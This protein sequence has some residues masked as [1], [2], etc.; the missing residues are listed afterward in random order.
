[1]GKNS[2]YIHLVHKGNLLKAGGWALQNGKERFHFAAFFFI[3]QEITPQR[4]KPTLFYAHGR[5]NEM[6]QQADGRPAHEQGRWLFPTRL[7]AISVILY[8]FQVEVLQGLYYLIERH[9]NDAEDNDGC[10]YHMEL[11]EVGSANDKKGQL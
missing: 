6:C 2:V 7:L 3:L 1:M 5:P 8:F 9:G 10:N 4:C 11:E